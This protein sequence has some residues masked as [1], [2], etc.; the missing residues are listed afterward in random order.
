MTP[1]TLKKIIREAIEEVKHEYDE[2]QEVMLMMQIQ[3]AA[4]W[5]KANRQAKPEDVAH[6]VDLIVGRI[7]ELIGMHK[8]MQEVAPAGWEGTVKAM[9]KHSDIDNPWALAHW[10]KGKGMKSHK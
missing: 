1:Q 7:D 5:L 8:K 10:M 4:H 2:R 6:A 9:K 3:S